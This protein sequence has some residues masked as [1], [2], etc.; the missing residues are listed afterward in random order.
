MTLLESLVAIIMLVAFTV[1]S[2]WSCNSRC[3]FLVLLNLVVE[4]NLEFRTVLI[5]HQQI[6]MAMD[7]LVEVYLNRVS[8]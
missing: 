4:M 3:V 8:V 7:S 6:Q 1:L 2:P 5:D